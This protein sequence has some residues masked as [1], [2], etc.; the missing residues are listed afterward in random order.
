[1]ARDV[2]G[3]AARIRAARAYAGLKQ[4]ELADALGVDVQTIKRREAGTSPPRRGELVAIADIC[5]VPVGFL[6]RG[7]AE[8]NRDEILE[9]LERIEETLAAADPLAPLRAYVERTVTELAS[10]ARETG[11]HLQGGAPADDL[12]LPAPARPRARSQRR[13]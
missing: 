7:F 1:M 2:G 13:S 3:P 12:A 9:R 11:P 5:K 4:E 6:K 10:E 8:A